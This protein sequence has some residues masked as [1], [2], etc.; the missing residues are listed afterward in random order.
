[1][2]DIT[3][4]L[5]IAL[6][7]LPLILVVAVAAGLVAYLYSSSQPAVYES[8]AT[9]RV[10]PGPDPSITD[11]AV[12]E[13]AAVRYAAQAE[14]RPVALAVIKKLKLDRSAAS[15]M[16]AI[17]TDVDEDTYE[18][19]I[20]ARD[21]DSQTAREVANA[22]GNEMV[23][24][25]RNSLITADVRAAENAI[26]RNE[27]SIRQLTN[28]LQVLRRKPNKDEFDRNEIISLT[29]QISQL[30]T[31]NQSY[32]PNSR[33]YVRNRLEWSERPTGSDEPVEPRPLIWALL[34]LVVAAMA[35]GSLAFV[36]EYLRTNG[37]IRDERDLEE[38]TGLLPLGTVT[39]D[40]RDVKRGDAARL[41]ML[42]YPRGDAAAAYRGL[43][44][45]IGFA[46][47]TSRTLLVT[48]ASDSDAKSAVAANLA[49]S[50]AEAG[51]N[52]ILV[53]ADYRSPR[54]H[55]FFGVRNDRGLTT[56]LADADVP[57]GWVTVATSHP[58]LGLM[59]SGPPPTETSDPLGSP[60]LATLLRR[61]L[62]AADMVV[63]DSPSMAGNLDAAVLAA[64][65][66]DALLVVTAG[67]TDQEAD[68]AAR[69]LLGSE[70]DVAGAVLYRDVRRSR[71][72][73]RR[74]VPPPPV[75]KPPA[76]PPRL[77]ARVPVPIARPGSANG[78]GA[79][80]GTGASEQPYRPTASAAVPPAPVQGGNGASVSSPKPSAQKPPYA[81]PYQPG[82]PPQDR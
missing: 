79:Q 55:S 18:L 54:L 59:P 78:A 26:A 68:D 3:R 50:Y 73:S 38:A 35:A 47:G 44:G 81:V 53:D 6:R 30:Q 61:L 62:N 31:A 34:A 40:R 21:G 1:L 8:T 65:V 74:Q 2:Q 52:V 46:S 28:R 13:A 37:K 69:A 72:G 19:T 7:W 80:G 36:L 56:I 17:E 11:L 66:Q 9:L 51:R 42:R 20:S 49:L 4:Q 29:G 67:A 22:Y 76:P 24:R 15:L 12:A 39:E 64:Q 5:G 58:R 27:A 77:P 63:F 75:S 14:S 71:R 60:Q 43:L 16:R 33:A 70:A 25:V 23:R 41:V 57:L 10:D 32:R 82:R 48:S 45:R